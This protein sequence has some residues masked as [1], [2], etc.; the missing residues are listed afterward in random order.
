MGNVSPALAEQTVH[1]GGLAMV[2]MG[3]DRD[4]AEARGIERRVRRDGG[5]SASS[6]GS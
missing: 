1:E 6:G 5:M 3:Y 4:V 2:N